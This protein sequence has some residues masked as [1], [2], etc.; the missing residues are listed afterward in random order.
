MNSE[1]LGADPRRFRN[2]NRIELGGTDT[3]LT[4]DIHGVTVDHRRASALVITA[5]GLR[6]RFLT[7][8]SH[9]T[10]LTP[11]TLTWP[12][13]PQHQPPPDMVRATPRDEIRRYTT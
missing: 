1:K 7:T 10:P 13:T 6:P 2:F 3:T 9:C 11:S 5:I 4:L 8:I 12:R